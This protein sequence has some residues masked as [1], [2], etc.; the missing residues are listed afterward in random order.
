MEKQV[1]RKPLSNVIIQPCLSKSCTDTNVVGL[2]L[3]LLA[4]F[5]RQSASLK[6][7]STNVGDYTLQVLNIDSDVIFNIMEQ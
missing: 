3:T 2:C 5:V 6:H 1:I 4:T 7:N